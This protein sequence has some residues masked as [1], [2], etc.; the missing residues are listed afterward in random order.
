MYPLPLWRAPLRLGRFV[1]PS[2]GPT[3]SFGAQ[4]GWAAATDDAA[5]ASILR[6]GTVGDSARGIPGSVPG[7]PVSRPTDGFKSSVDFRL[8]FLGGALSIGVARA[9]DHH[10]PWRFVVG[11]AQVL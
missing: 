3:L 5:R 7:A 4:G 6:L 9:T 2:V 1:L 11:F 10:E 8:R